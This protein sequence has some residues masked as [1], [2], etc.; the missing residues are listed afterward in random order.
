MKV[1]EPAGH[2]CPH[3]ERLNGFSDHLESGIQLP[4]GL[5]HLPDAIALDIHL[6]PRTDLL[7]LDGL[8]LLRELVVG[9]LEGR[10]G[11]HS[12][13]RQRHEPHVLPL[14]LR[15]RKVEIQHAPLMLCLARLQGHPQVRQVGNLLG[16]VRLSRHEIQAECRI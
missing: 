6:D 5:L 9:I 2:R 7:V 13:V 15:Q 4:D 16:P 11:N 8:A 10:N 12:A 1:S 3:G 14:R